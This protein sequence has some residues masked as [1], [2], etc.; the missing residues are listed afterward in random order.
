MCKSQLLFNGP[1][2]LSKNAVPYCINAFFVE[3]F[4]AA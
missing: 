3:D 2:C 1:Y 4:H